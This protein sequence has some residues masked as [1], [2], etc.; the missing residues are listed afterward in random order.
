MK[1]HLLIGIKETAKSVMKLSNWA[2]VFIIIM[3]ILL[4]C[5]RGNNKMLRN[6]G[7]GTNKSFS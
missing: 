3:L 2:K 7:F 6:E 1:N 5:Y 4:L